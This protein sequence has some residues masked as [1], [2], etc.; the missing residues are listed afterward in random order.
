M[1]QCQEKRHDQLISKGMYL[2]VSSYVCTACVC[3]FKFILATYYLASK[4]KDNLRVFHVL[5]Y[6]FYFM[7]A[8]EYHFL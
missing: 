5:L 2:N 3:F 8:E 6:I 4:D 1:F 7:I